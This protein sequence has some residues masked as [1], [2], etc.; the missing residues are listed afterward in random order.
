MSV[1]EGFLYLWVSKGEGFRVDL[2][3]GVQSG[4]WLLGSVGSVESAI[5][6]SDKWCK[7]DIGHCDS[8]IVL[9]VVSLEYNSRGCPNWCQ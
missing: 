3:D 5:S 7:F 4:I 6:N 9:D 2:V 8:F 1:L